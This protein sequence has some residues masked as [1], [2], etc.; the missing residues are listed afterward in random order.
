MIL[1]APLNTTAQDIPFYQKLF[2][3]LQYNTI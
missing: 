3:I 2:K 1:M